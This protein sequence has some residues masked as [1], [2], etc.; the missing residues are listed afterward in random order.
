MVSLIFVGQAVGFI[1]GAALIDPMRE[2][3]GRARTLALAQAFMV[4]GYI[5]IACTAP[6]SAVVI[7]F[8]LLGLGM[9]I[10]LSLGNVF[11]GSL[12]NST[13]ALGAMHGSYGI[14]GITGPLI[15]TAFVTAGNMVWSRYYILTLC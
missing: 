6:F 10:N 2:R 3:L 15:A 14:G 7:A 4:G 5:I 9:S 1:L 8:F 11:C 13:T 12:I